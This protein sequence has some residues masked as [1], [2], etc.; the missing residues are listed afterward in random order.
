[1]DLFDSETGK[2]YEAGI[3]LLDESAE[4]QAWNVEARACAV[5]V[6]EA[7]GRV[8]GDRSLEAKLE[9]V[10]AL[11]Q[12][13]NA[14]VHAIV[15]RLLAKD[16]VVGVVG[17]DHAAPFGAIEAHASKW[18]GLG[19]LHVDAHAD[20]RRAYEGFRWSHASIMESVMRELGGIGKLVQVGVRDLCEEE[21]ERIVASGGR[22]RTIYDVDVARARMRG[23]LEKLFDEAVHE[24]PQ[25]VYVSFDIDGL[26]PS[27]CPHTGTPVPGGLSFHEANTLLRAV[28]EA[29]RTI[30]GFDL[31]EVAPAP[32][33]ED[34]WD[35][36]VGARLLYK[37][38][39]WTLR[40]R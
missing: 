10:N 31:D 12:L 18:P 8:D 24:L 23:T 13:V 33:G 36:N 6:I 37:M 28:V 38:I 9:R 26:D 19:I 30:V 14:R 39:G 22:I 4:I 5:A 16:K 35:A 3:M 20:L 7:G 15:T 21:H 34:E 27:L 17:G 1:V 40:S 25:H 2:P 11:S 32:D 29:K